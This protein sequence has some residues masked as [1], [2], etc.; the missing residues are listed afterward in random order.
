MKTNKRWMMMIFVFFA[1]VINYVDRTVLG[2][3]GPAIMEDIGITNVQ[4][5]VLASAFFWS[6]SL[7]NIPGGLIADKIGTKIT[8]FGS[9][10][11]WSLATVL[12]G[13][14]RTFGFMI[15]SRVLMGLGESPAFPANTRI[16]SEWMPSSERGKANSMMTSAMAVGMGFLSVGI[17]WIITTYGWRNAFIICGALG[18]LM[19]VI[20]A[21][22]FKEKPED[23]KGVN[24]EELDFIRAGQPKQGK[25]STDFRWYHALK[26][27]EIWVLCFGL[28]TTN[29][30]MYMMLTWLPT[31]LVS[32][33]N[34]ILLNAGFSSIAPYLAMFFGAILG[35]AFSDF[36]INRKG[37][38]PLKARKYTLTL[39]MLMMAV[40]IIPAPYITSNV[41]ALALMSCAMFAIGTLGANVWAAVAD[42]TPKSA[43]AGVAGFQNFVGQFAGIL[44][45]IVTGVLVQMTNSYNIAFV[46]SGIF[47]VIAAILYMAVIKEFTL[48]ESDTKIAVN[49]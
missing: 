20:W 3:A 29:Y 24:K 22:F 35:G 38:A 40:F 21:V 18:I 34:M 48:T 13:L 16:I 10:I 12:T 46:I 23:H 19:A 31:Y 45:P 9:L 47:G 42:I 44:A 43:V 5:G 25:I 17:A 30:L 39:A 1:T 32:V 41:V 7:G 33:R 28:F 14:S 49:S 8:Y 4:F 6:Y 36:L 2:L 15:G 26:Y 37:Y 27:K 11:V